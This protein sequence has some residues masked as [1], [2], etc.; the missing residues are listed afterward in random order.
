[1][2]LE[3][4]YGYAVMPRLLVQPDLQ[5]IINPGGNR[6]IPNALAIVVNVVVNF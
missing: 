4:M 1:M 6:D 5:Y 2:T 3:L